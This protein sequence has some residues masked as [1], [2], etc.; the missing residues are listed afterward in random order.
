MLDRVVGEDVGIEVRTAS[1]L[2]T[3][4]MDPAQIEQV[5]MNL[6]VNA[7]DAMP[8]GGH[9]VIETANPDLDEAYAISHP[10]TTPGRFMMLAV[11]DTGIGM[12]AETRRHLFEPFFTTKAPGEGTG[13]GLA[14]VYGIVKQNGG[15]I[16]VYSEVGRGTTFKV[17]LPRLDEARAEERPASADVVVPRGHETVPVVEDMESVR[18]MI[19]ETLEGQGYTVPVASNGEEALA[20]VRERQG[21]IHLLLTDVVMP[22]LG[23]GDLARQVSAL[24][25]GTPV[26]FMSGYPEGVISRDGALDDGVEILEK[27]FSPARLALAVRRALDRTKGP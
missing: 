26:L 6:V 11:S 12:D 14:T 20:L 4:K 17:Y 1:D 10:P 7:R 13:L 2:G 25:P 16:R 27:P 21:P 9:L 3:V 19:R 23:G 24:R 15:Y 5:I 18:E 22:K 8:D